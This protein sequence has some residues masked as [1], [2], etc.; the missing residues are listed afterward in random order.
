[1]KN[2]I[3]K[4]I[5]V[6]PSMLSSTVT[7]KSE[8]WDQIDKCGKSCNKRKLGRKCTFHELEIILLPWHL[9]AHTSDIPVDGNMLPGKARHIA[10]RI[11]D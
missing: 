6:S 2:P 11:A 8:I 9:Q 3:E 7:K 1:V 5:D 4:Q 10:Y